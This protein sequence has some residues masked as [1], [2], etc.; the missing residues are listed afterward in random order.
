MSFVKSAI[1][2]GILTFISRIFGYIRD[3][4]IASQLGAGLYADVF[5]V[6]FRLPNFFRRLF[7]EGAFSSAF[8]PL[9]AG[10]LAAE[11]EKPAKLFAERVFTILLMVLVVFTILMQ[12]FMPWVMLL[13]APGFV[14]EKEKFD[15]AVLLSR[16]TMPYLLFISLVSLLSGVL[17]SLNRFA[18]AAASPILL[19]FCMVLSIAWLA[20]YTKTPAHALSYG[21]A[22]AGVVQFIALIFSC[23]RAGMLIG[24]RRPRLDSNVKRLLRNMMPGV[25]GGG[26]MQINLWIDTI[27][28]TL[29]PQGAVSLLYYADRINQLPMALIGTA[30]GTVM[31]P[32]LSRQMREG[33]KE[34]AINTQNRALEVAL[35]LSLP[36]TVALVL[37]A[38]PLML[39][40]FQRGE[41]GAAETSGAAMALMA[42]AVGLPAFVMVK[43]FT[44]CFFAIYDTK[45]PV[46]IA[47]A[48]LV[49]NIIFNLL[50]IQILGHV[51]IALATS[52]SS[53]LNAA[54]L[55]Y[56]LVKRGIFKAD[57]QLCAR[58]PRMVFACVVMGAVLILSTSL[59]HMPLYGDNFLIRVISFAAIIGAGFFTFLITAHYSRA[60]DI[61]E[62][63]ELLARRKKA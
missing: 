12:I 8:V 1:V 42:F 27:I 29:L 30:I 31:L 61:K 21:V 38:N 43:I 22:L 7:A 16:I 39:V 51:G 56:L 58:A 28:A 34:Q 45:T 5:L 62:I 54:A 33:N 36:C 53:W 2:I 55:W 50:L 41:F 13:L 20:H 23:K 52:I 40:L 14:D 11:G 19:N 18:A 44:P 6:A 24:F 26:V 60:F 10:M 49:A 48:C 3:I 15:L 57:G 25:I 17:N 4:F 32:L 9:F 59:L 35:L 37:I 47:M 63:K 46:K